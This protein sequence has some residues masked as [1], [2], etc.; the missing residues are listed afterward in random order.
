MV[1]PPP[2]DITHAP[3][4]CSWQLRPAACMMEDN[5]ASALPVAPT[6]PTAKDAGE[7]EGF[8]FAAPRVC[9]LVK[10]VWMPKVL[11]SISPTHRFLVLQG[12]LY[13]A[14]GCTFMGSPWLASLLFTFGQL[15]SEVCQAEISARVCTPGHIGGTLS[16]GL[17]RD[18]KDCL[19]DQERKLLQFASFS[20]VV[21][22]YLYIQLA[23]GNTLHFV[24]ASIFNRMVLVTVRVL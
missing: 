10:M 7:G 8:I 11:E 13:C 16:S 22:G 20:A 23:R 6:L 19:C 17:L 4:P 14:A 15:P 18:T 2:R 21:V 24:G 1:L 12:I 9:E 5:G 3:A